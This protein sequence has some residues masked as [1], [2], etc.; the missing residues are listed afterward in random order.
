MNQIMKKSCLLLAILA[1]LLSA[2]PT[3]GQ[4]SEPIRDQ[5]VIPA[6][7]QRSLGITDP[8]DTVENS[9]VS[10][11][12]SAESGSGS[13][14]LDSLYTDLSQQ[15]KEIELPK[16][17]GSLAIVLGGYLGFVW[18]TRKLGHGGNQ[19]LPSEVVEVLGQTQFG[20]RKQLQLVR[21]GSKLLLLLNHQDGSTQTIGEITDPHEVDYLSSVCGN[22]NSSR[23]AIAIGKATASAE[24]NNREASSE[25]K[26]VLHQLQKSTDANPVGSV[27]DA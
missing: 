17:L 20:P 26:R 13:A 8:M 25:L 5:A 4:G 3:Q 2:E 7:F 24:R 1:S 9:A 16:V 12:D 10:S 19:G 23:S 21:L 11:G 18:L 27:F 14:A 15:A 6:D 22:S